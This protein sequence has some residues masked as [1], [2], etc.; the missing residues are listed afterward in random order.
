[1]V[2]IDIHLRNA[3]EKAETLY[4]ALQKERL[5][6]VGDMA[7]KVAEEAVLAYESREDPYSTHRRTQ[8]FYIV[9]TELGE[10]ERKCFRRLH[11][12]YERLGYGGSNGDLAEEAVKCME[13]IVKRVESEL[14]VKILPEEVSR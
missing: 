7:Y 13:K 3:R 1:M 4:E 9:K 11:R 2:S 14:D 5:S 12:I 8:T 10:S 6:V